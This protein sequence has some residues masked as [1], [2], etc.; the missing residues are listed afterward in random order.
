MMNLRVRAATVVAA[1]IVV[2]PASRAGAQVPLQLV[3]PPGN[4]GAPVLITLS[5]AIERA[6][7]LD[8]QSLSSQFDAQ[9]ASE[10]RTQARAGMLPQ[11]SGTSQY[12]GTQG[13]GV[14]PSGRFVS[15]DGVHMYRA[16]GVLHQDLSPGTLL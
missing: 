13:N 1:L 14:L 5:D 9:I 2:M 10:D 8:G 3:Q 16:W 4:A 7:K 12:L 6:R 15:N 11:L